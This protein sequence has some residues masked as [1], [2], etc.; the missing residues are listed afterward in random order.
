[1]SCAQSP[2]PGPSTPPLVGAPAASDLTRAVHVFRANPT[3]MALVGQLLEPGAEEIVIHAY[4]TRDGQKERHLVSKGD[5][6]AL[7][8][9]AHWSSAFFREH[10]GASAQTSGAIINRR[11]IAQEAWR[12]DN[13]GLREA[14]FRHLDS[15]NMSYRWPFFQNV[16]AT[17][18]LADL[19]QHLDLA[20]W[21]PHHR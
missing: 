6:P 7:I 15:H 21:E 11:E 17:M 13:E 2:A 19:G 9:E 4:T 20:R 18:P 14:V 8:A 10:P 12:G 5:M 3:V 16:V 1:M